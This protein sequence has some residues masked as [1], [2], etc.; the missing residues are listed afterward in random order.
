[1]GSHPVNLGARFLLELCAL[2]A[3]GYWGWARHRGALRVV[4]AIGVPL[5][6]AVLWGTLAVPD[7]PSRSGH[8]PVPVPGI[9]RLALELAVFGFASWALHHAGHTALSLVLAGMVILHYVVSH[10]R[11]A[12]LVRQ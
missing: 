5:V 8:A 6:L 7:D 1:M 4:A 3:G 12:W 2:A 9:L 10:D 11:V